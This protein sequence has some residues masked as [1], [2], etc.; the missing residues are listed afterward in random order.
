[1]TLF[2]K[3]YILSLFF[4]RCFTEIKGLFWKNWAAIQCLLFGT[5]AAAIF[6]IS[7]VRNYKLYWQ[8]DIA[9]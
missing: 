8:F 7:L 4:F 1:M 9:I 5:I 3:I 2:F 6:A